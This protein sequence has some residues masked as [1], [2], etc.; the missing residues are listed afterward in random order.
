MTNH[1]IKRQVI[2]L[3]V[4]D[5]ASA[6]ALQ[7]QVSH[8]YR[9]RIVPLIDR[10]CT[11]LGAPDRLYR[12]D[13]LELDLGT[14][15]AEQFE[16]QFVAQVERALQKALREQITSQEA[17]TEEDSPKMRSAL[18]LF[19]FFVQM[20]SLPWWADQTRPAL[21]RENL[22]TLLDAPPP[23]FVRLLQEMIRDGRARQRLVTE[24]ADPQL[25]ALCGQLAPAHQAALK[26]DAPTLSRVIQKTKLS[27]GWQPATLRK[28][29]WN[30]LLQT[31][32][33]DGSQYPSRE[34]FY[35][36]A[37]Q[38]LALELGTTYTQLIEQM[39]QAVLKDETIPNSTEKAL[40]QIILT[41]SA[42][43]SKAEQHEQEPFQAKTITSA[44]ADL[45]KAEQR[46]QESLQTQTGNSQTNDAP[47]QKK[48]TNK[49]LK[50]EI[51]RQIQ[52]LY[53]SEAFATHK[54]TH[55]ERTWLIELLQSAPDKSPSE[56]A[57]ELAAL[58]QRYQSAGGPL[59]KFWAALRILSARLPAPVQTAW[60]ETLNELDS[61]ET[62]EALVPLL[63][64]PQSL[65]AGDRDKVFTLLRAAKAPQSASASLNLHFSDADELP[66]QNA[67]LVILWPFLGSF[68]DHLG[69]LEERQFK[70]LAARQRAT[71]L[72]QILA[73][74]EPI[75][76][77]Y[78]LPLNK[79]L[80][81]LDVQ[82]V[83]DF[84]PPARKVELRECKSL[85]KAV[86]AQAPI[87]N[88][89]SVDGF[90]GS[91]LV[92]PG[93]LSTRDGHWLLRVEHQT[94]DIVL[95]RFPW[96]WQWVKLPWME[97]P[98]RVEWK[99]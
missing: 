87:L 79:L 47:Q 2:E 39:Q 42:S 69:L 65:P 17:E 77:E 41:A 44:S 24:Y 37:L 5:P 64:A 9:Q 60:L 4:Q 88:N 35:Q 61:E 92:R 10:Y 98:L 86:I 29:L 18:E 70:D 76:A 84:G 55:A 7:D 78:Q 1:I 83:F 89:M 66:V 46:N 16:E 25:I 22:Q 94:Y 21:L 11:A 81:G 82:Q 71:G 80:C 50:P 95:E 74:G 15:D 52:E 90:R 96:S 56:S 27:L 30:N 36:A 8:I 93:L 26:Q 67:G 19:I 51:A 34:A 85:L 45:A 62:A 63:N 13:L 54:L 12:I 40:L 43:L 68:F 72:L 6:R 91:F 97:T 14:L 20:G 31:A 23:D 33:L 49:A 99:I 75:F 48:R 73:T 32:S 38:R 3:T 59:S 53:Q 57:K 28:Q 58:F